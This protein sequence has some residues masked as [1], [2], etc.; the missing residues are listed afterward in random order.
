M[1][2][3]A[4]KKAFALLITCLLG[5]ASLAH[6]QVY[7]VA[8]VVV[9]GNRRVEQSAILSLLSAKPGQVVSIETIDKD[10]QAIYQL[11][12]FEDVLALVT[13]RNGVNTLVYQVEERPLV[14]KVE[15]SG[16][17]EFDE[18]KLQSLITL[19][20]PDIYE[21]RVIDESIRAIK[22]AY[23]ADGYH[24]VTVQMSRKDNERYETT[25]TFKID[26]GDKALVKSIKFTGN[27]VLTDRQLKKVMGTKER[28]LFSWITG[29]GAFLEEVLKNDL[30]MIA[31]AYYN[32]GY[33]QVKIKEPIVML[34]DDKR[35]LTITLQIEEGDQFKVGKIDIKGDLLK[36]KSEMLDLISFKNGNIFSRSVLRSNVLLLNDLYGD[37]GYAYVN[38][39]PLSRLD[40]DRQIVDLTFDIEKGPQ[41]QISRINISG[42][43]RTR[44]KVIRREMDFVEG[45]LFNAT[46]LKESRRL[47]NNLGFFE[48][49]DLTTRKTDDESKMNVD[50]SVKERP[51]GNFTVGAG[52]SSVDSFVFQGSVSQENFLGLALGLNLSGSFGGKSTTYNI[53]L[54]DPHFLDSKYTVGFDLYKTEREYTEY[55]KESTGGDIKL[56]FPLAENNRAFFIYRYEQKTIS[57]VDPNATLLITSQEGESTLSAISATL[58][59]E[60]TDYRLDPTRGYLTSLTGDFAGLGGTQYFSKVTLDHRH[61]LQAFGSTYF[62]LHGQ[63]GQLF[64]IGDNEIPIDERFLLGGINSLRG[65]ESR[66]V[67]PRLQRSTDAVDPV[68]GAIL[69]TS[70]TFDY[71]GGVKKAYMNLE[72][73][74]PLYK[75]LGLKGLVFF[76]TGNAWGEDEDFFSDMRY[77]VGA[78]IRWFSPMGPLRLEWGFNLDPTEDEADSQF[79]FSIGRFY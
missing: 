54:T 69:G 42:N 52:Y 71:I 27:K 26:E 61:Y 15:F 29:R 7:R 43:T 68:S 24:A 18:K 74:F 47:V 38:V 12:R 40:P 78:G 70:D 65:F 6:A 10:I 11:G 77:S 67:G 49:V 25:V 16:N 9:E 28:W 14:R 35:D 3:S 8:D 2:F 34:S 20:V 46:G 63:I 23:V 79:E 36:P 73:V 30:E 4:M 66:K 72:Y 41:V 62:V 50:V 55:D 31:D 22:D 5:A 17:S 44:D 13:E 57:N 32:I 48:S 58:S 56:G 75:D 76:D 37:Q 39:S 53:G 19:K 45:D 21:P 59:R 64:K 1:E 51:T 33:L 60:T